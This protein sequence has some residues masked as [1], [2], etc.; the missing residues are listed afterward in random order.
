[1]PVS[2]LV[3][4]DARAPVPIGLPEVAQRRVQETR[5]VDPPMRR[6]AVGDRMTRAVADLKEALG[7]RAAAAGKAIAAVRVAREL[8]AELLEPVDRRLRVPGERLDQRALGSL[9]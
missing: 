8:D 5:A 7:A 3:L 4:A 6:A 2:S 1:M 9:V